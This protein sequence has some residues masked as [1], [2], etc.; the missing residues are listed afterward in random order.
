MTMEASGVTSYRVP[1]G[2]G[3]A[4]VEIKRSR[5]LCLVRRVESEAE[6]RATISARRRAFHDARHTCSAFLLG[7]HRDV[8][9]S[10]DDGEPAGTAGA[11][12]LDALASYL[13]APYLSDSVAVVTRWFGGV[14]LGTGG[15]TRAYA[16]AVTEA[17]GHTTMIT[18][19]LRRSY[20]VVLGYDVAGRLETSIRGAGLTVTDVGHAVDGVRLRIAA[21]AAEPPEAVVARIGEITSGLGTTIPSTVEWTDV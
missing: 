21:S 1:A 9:R 14:L 11:P 12:M 2:E 15:L 18:R 20:E 17:L 10:S 13:P 6:A 5:F 8:A 3:E 16:Q 7:P 4:E 19:E